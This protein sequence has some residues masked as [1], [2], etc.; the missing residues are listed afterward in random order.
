MRGVSEL[1]GASPAA[2]YRKQYAPLI[3]ST[4]RAIDEASRTVFGLTM[5]GDKRQALEEIV[6]GIA[7]VPFEFAAEVAHIVEATEAG[8]LRSAMFPAHGE[9][10]G[11]REPA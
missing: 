7:V 8:D 9:F 4:D 11:L 10:M 6:D 5:M 3:Y 1:I 2:V